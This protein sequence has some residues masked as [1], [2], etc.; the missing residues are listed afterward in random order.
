VTDQTTW[1]AFDTMNRETIVNGVS[2]DNG[3][4]VSIGG[5]ANTS[6]GQQIAY[7]AAG[8]RIH[9]S[10]WGKGL[11]SAGN[12]S[13]TASGNNVL[14]SES[15]FYDAAGR[16]DTMYREGAVADS[17]RYD[18]DG[19]LLEAGQLGLD[20]IDAAKLEAMGISA[21][22]RISAYDAGGRMAQQAVMGQNWRA[23]GERPEATIGYAYDALGRVSAYDTSFH[24]AGY[25]RHYDYSYTNR[26]AQSV[27]RIEVHEVVP[28]ADDDHPIVQPAV[29]AST[30]NT[31]DANGHLT[32]VQGT[33]Q[34]DTR[35]IVSDAQG[36]VLRKTSY[37]KENNVWV[38]HE[39][40]TLVVNGEEIGSSS[41]DKQVKGTFNAD[42]TPTGGFTGS[43]FYTVQAGDTL[44][45]I[46]KAFWGD[47][48]LW[49]LIADANGGSSVT[50]GQVILIPAK[51]NTATDNSSTF[52]PYDP[53]KA[54]GDTTPT[55]PM[56][57][58]HHG[59]C[60]GVGQILAIVV[61]VVATVFTAG[62]A[63]IAL[64]EAAGSTA[65]AGMTAMEA[66]LALATGEA[67]AGGL[68]MGIAVAAGAIGGAVGSVAGQVTS[69]ATGNQHGFSWKGV[70]LGALAG[71]V[72]A[73]VAGELGASG[74]LAGKSA[75][76][77]AA[78]AAIANTL[79]QG[80]GVATG[81]QHSFSWQAVAASA[82]GAGVGQAVSGPLGNAFGG[83]AAGQ[84]GARLAT[85]VVAGG[86]AALT[87]GGRVSVQQVAV[88]AF[89]N[90]IGSSLVDQQT[91]SGINA[92][93]NTPLATGDF[94][95]MD[96]AGYRSA[97]Y[98][99][100]TGWADAIAMR[101]RMNYEQMPSWAKD[102]QGA[103][104][105]AILKGADG[106]LSD[107]VWEMGRSGI[108][109]AQT[110]QSNEAVQ[111]F[112]FEQRTAFN[113]ALSQPGVTIDGAVKVGQLVGL[114]Q[115]FDA[116]VAKIAFDDPRYPE[117]ARRRDVFGDMLLSYDSYFAKS[118]A[119][120]MPAD[121]QRVSSAVAQRL[122]GDATYRDDRS[123]FFAALY[124]NSRSG[125][126]TLA[127][128]GT[129]NWEGVQADYSQA[130]GRPT[131][132]YDQAVALASDL[133]VA[134]GDKLSF[135]GHSLGGG[136]AS[137][138][139]LDTNLTANTF[140]A[141]GINPATAQ[142]YEVSLKA[143]KGLVNAY[144]V[145]GEVLSAAQDAGAITIGLPTLYAKTLPYTQFDIPALA[146]IA[147]SSVTVDLPE[148][149]GRRIPL[150]P[151]SSEGAAALH[152]SAAVLE[153]IHRWTWD[154]RQ[155][156]VR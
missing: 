16:L 145:K 153:A 55:A 87:R 14:T 117:I 48:N 3:A 88:D 90:A 10:Q 119:Q 23:T 69:I 47:S 133:K 74:A 21:Q 70:A 113:T 5:D 121:T 92:P 8:R 141:A 44:Q 139:A 26:D 109:S 46:A 43:T 102:P 95:R 75:P 60:G 71:G 64:A 84:F 156:L 148:A 54:I 68:S 20:N 24:H 79:T 1:N 85:G 49:Y 50:Q 63:A 67:V 45:G 80:I 32:H 58:G 34:N 134:L 131:L 110:A 31:Y 37:T 123:G 136:L 22:T 19:R 27:D 137:I 93:D 116:E 18:Q 57:Q 122:A 9:V 129:A 4:H 65:L 62:A 105:L 12:G 91:S 127:F 151:A 125:Q 104:T 115:Q 150:E 6:Q 144:Y 94:A 33:D 38:Q 99:S 143:A 147:M 146:P 130:L 96:G 2:A 73:G 29:I 30:T 124:E 142:H 66:G 81:L 17:R 52:K 35:E 76:M 120:L 59:G 89:G 7:D 118:I 40:H 154:V 41:S 86:A 53:S 28:G 39:T 106:V 135:T 101:N 13:F 51:P 97:P 61:A 108:T 72:G 11:V 98:D 152:G 149:A 140:N 111:S 36:H 83:T 126:Y 78:R 114:R 107:A 138:A 132:Q 100:G 56:P 112:N 25:A 103:A 155:L 15:N 77:L 42:Y 82:V 128:R